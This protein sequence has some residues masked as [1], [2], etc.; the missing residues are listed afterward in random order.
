[1][2]WEDLEY[3]TISGTT[4]I[5]LLVKLGLDPDRIKNETEEFASYFEV[6]EALMRE[7]F[8]RALARVP[9][10]EF[11]DAILNLCVLNMGSNNENTVQFSEALIALVRL[12]LEEFVLGRGEPNDSEEGFGESDC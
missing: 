4:F 7:A 6:Q 2:H 5:G 10:P 9:R 3:R 12:E 11:C 1:M 8:Q